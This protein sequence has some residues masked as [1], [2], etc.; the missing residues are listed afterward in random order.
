V[1]ELFVGEEENVVDSIHRPPLQ[2]PDQTS[3]S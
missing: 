3:S 2:A 1:D